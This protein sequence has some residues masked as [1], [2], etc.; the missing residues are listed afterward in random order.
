M[1]DLLKHGF[2]CM[3]APAGSR[4]DIV[5]DFGDIGMKRI[6]VKSVLGLRTSSGRYKSYMFRSHKIYK[7]GDFD[8]IA[9]VALDVDII[10]YMLPAEF[11]SKHS[12]KFQPPDYQSRWRKTNYNID[13]FPLAKVLKQ[14]KE[15]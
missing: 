9:M 12:M 6:Q 13:S 3:Q 14:I 1:I 2:N 10:A 5:A 11:I 8:I 7:P 4:Y 15:A